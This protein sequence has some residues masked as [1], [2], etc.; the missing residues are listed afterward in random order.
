MPCQATL[1]QLVEVLNAASFNWS[2]AHGGVLA[3]GIATDS[4]TIQ[5]GQVFLALRGG[6]FDGHNFLATAI[7][8]GAS[9]AIVDQQFPVS[10]VDALPLLQVPDTLAAYQAIAHWWRSQFQIPIIGITGSVGK[11]T[12]KELVAAVLAAPDSSDSPTTAVLKTQANYNNEIGVPKTLL[13]LGDE[14]RF[15]VIE[16]GMRGSGEVALLAQI[17][18]PTIALITNVGTAHLERL[19]SEDA[20]AR[21]ECESLLE[22]GTDGIAILNQD[23]AR[24]MATAAECW[25]GKTVT[26]G[27]AG[28]DLQGELLDQ[29]TLKVGDRT[30]P[31]PLPGRHNAL[32]Y[33]AALTVAQVLGV[34]WTPLQAG[35]SVSLPGGRAKRYELANDILLLDETYNAGVESMIAT[36]HLLA[37]TPGNRHI[38]VLGTM[39]ELGPR[40]PE[41]HQRV[42]ETVAQLQLDHLLILADEPEAS[43]L[44]TGAGSVPSTCFSHHADLIH[45]LTTLV[46]AGDRLLFKASRSVGLDRVV[47]GLLQNLGTG[48]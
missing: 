47:A 4:R 25:Q 8:Q 41:F 12:T 14:H 39:R 9:A 43:A 22:L 27:F 19:G 46:Q 29:T 11:T 13:G 3:T 32:N 23:D 33:L 40:S 35:V 16:M 37:Q 34:D 2:D 21:A 10:S 30:F 7:A 24:L 44:A 15:A 38:A 6:N 18:R 17:A 28:G 42:G 5:P 31:L 1:S 26:F 48:A 36:L 45:H 20:I